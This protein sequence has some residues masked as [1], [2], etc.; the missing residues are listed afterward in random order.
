MQ[1]RE[2]LQRSLVGM[3]AA[4]A[5]SL[6]GVA[7]GDAKSFAGFPEIGKHRPGARTLK[8]ITSD[9]IT[10]LRRPKWTRAMNDLGG[11]TA[12]LR[13]REMILLIY[14]H[15][16]GHRGKRLEGTGEMHALAS[17]DHGK[18]WERLPNPPFEVAPE[19]VVARDQLFAYDW[20]ETEKQPRVRTST[21]GVKWS[22]VKPIYKQPFYL[23]GVMYD[24]VSDEFWAPPHAI[25]SKAAVEGRQIHLIRS[26][27]GVQWDYVSTVAP[28]NNSSE[29]VLR[30]E[31]DRSMTVLIRRKYGKTVTV[32]TAK[33]PYSDWQMSDL[34]LIAE[35]HHFFEIGGHT[36]LGS[37]A[38][39]S[40]EHAEV[41]ANPP[42]FDNR[43]SY[44]LI[45]DFTAD[46]QLKPWA[47]VDSLGDCSYPFLVETPTEILCAYY[48][49]HED[50]VCKPF[51]C[52]FDKREFLS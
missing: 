32:A 4:A 26:K 23:W 31:K 52:G 24:P 33:P 17:R 30:F 35:G 15:V 20:N 5:A 6:T 7:R 21:D 48:S 1:R 34:P 11:W 22:D 50:G 49:Q 36:F 41:N 14:P 44:T 29:S 3:S 27:D 12:M 45:Y 19:L 40:G 28:F 16:D 25:P 46:R 10:G 39:Y 42:I 43:R 8:V 9:A 51:L 47:V 2:F 13:F 38:N 18:S 37:R